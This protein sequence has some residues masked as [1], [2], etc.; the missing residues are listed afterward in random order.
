MHVC[1]CVSCIT[2]ETK[3]LSRNWRVN[4]KRKE[5]K[6]RR[7]KIVSEREGEEMVGEILASMQAVFYTQPSLS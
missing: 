4:M 7:L 5:V 1:V 6:E 3:G 2:L